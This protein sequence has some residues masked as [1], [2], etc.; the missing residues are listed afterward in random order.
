[1]FFTKR[2]KKDKKE[3]MLNKVKNNYES[4]M[5]EEEKEFFKKNSLATIWGISHRYSSLYNN[6]R[7]LS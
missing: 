3:E 2:E 5:S 4:K 7:Y 1:M 6:K